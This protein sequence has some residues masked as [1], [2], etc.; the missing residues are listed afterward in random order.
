VTTP[1]PAQSPSDAPGLASLD[2]GPLRLYGD[3]VRHL[4]VRALLSCTHGLRDLADN[5][6]RL[7][8][9]LEDATTRNQ[10]V[11]ADADRAASRA[12][13]PSADRRPRLVAL[14]SLADNRFDLQFTHRTGHGASE[15]DPDL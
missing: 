10:A 8:W 15:G 1:R 14:P 5:L 2:S 3:A 7:R 9:R 4:A 12:R 6:T 11:A 13:H